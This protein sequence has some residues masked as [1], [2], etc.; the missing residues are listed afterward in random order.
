MGAFAPAEAAN[1]ALEAEVARRIVGPILKRMAD[2]GSPFRGALYCGLMVGR[3]GVQVVEFNVRFGDPETQA[4]MPLLEG[5]LSALLASAAAGALKPECI[6]RADGAA[7]AVALVDSGYPGQVS[8]GGTLEGLGTLT[9]FDDLMVFHAGTRD[10][11]GTWR[12]CGG[13]AL[14]VAAQASTCEAARARVYAGID[15]LGGEGWRCRRDI[16]APTESAAALA[17]PVAQGA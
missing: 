2:L 1:S 17:W 7:V 11:C 8:G 6:G 3:S 15:G 10:E 5:S 16:A 9:Q 4:M 12:L 13:R 14:Y